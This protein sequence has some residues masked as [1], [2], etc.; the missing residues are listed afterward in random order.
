M[1]RDRIQT[2]GTSEDSGSAR[3]CYESISPQLS[4]TSRHKIRRQSTAYD[5]CLNQKSGPPSGQA[6]PQSNRRGSRPFLSPGDEDNYGGRGGRRDSLSPDSAAEDSVRKGRRDSGTVA[7]N[8]DKDSRESSPRALW[9]RAGR[10]KSSSATLEEKLSR[11]KN[12]QQKSH[13]PDSSSSREPSP[14]FGE[15]II[16]DRRRFMI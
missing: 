8:S 11:K 9:R 5:E 10:R 14:K 4:P 16:L 7:A 3:G 13:S 15:G 6:Q 2:S 12:K 1:L